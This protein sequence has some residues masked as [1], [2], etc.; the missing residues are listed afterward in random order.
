LQRASD[1]GFK[2]LWV[3]NACPLRKRI[4]QQPEPDI[5]VL[6]VWP[7]S[8]LESVRLRRWCE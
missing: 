6:V 1:F 8:A 7:L 3:G 4:T 5:A 2:E